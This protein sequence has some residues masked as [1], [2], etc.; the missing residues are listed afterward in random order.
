MSL[1]INLIGA[2]RLGTALGR[3]ISTLTDYHLLG[4]CNKHWDKTQK[5]AN[6]INEGE[7]YQAIFQL[8]EADITFIVTPDD[9]I[10]SVAKT[11]S[12]SPSLKPGSIVAHCSGVLDNSE[13]QALSEKGCLT[14]SVHPMRSFAQPLH[15][16]FKHAFCAIEGNEQAC[17]VL[18]TLFS[19]LGAT[20]LPI[21][22]D[23]KPSYHTA[24]VFGSNF[25]I[26]LTSLATEA[27]KKAGL[28]HE[29]AMNTT[30]NLMQGSLDN[31]KRTQD[32]QA[33]LT[34]PFARGDK[35]TISRHID[36]LTGTAKTVYIE[37]GKLTLALGT[38]DDAKKECINELLSR[39]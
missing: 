8:P 5:A 38:L 11:L 31:L 12:N 30:L 7:A 1:T 25:L 18:S 34:G 15:T 22:G 35:D 39:A 21:Q 16:D 23:L 17:S 4:L 33:S 3:A 13:L 36:T 26:T 37:L 6:I 14:A 28:T 9:R 20:V 10:S 29:Q 19:E 27:L 2:G 32:I 24:G